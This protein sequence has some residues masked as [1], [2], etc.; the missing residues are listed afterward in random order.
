MNLRCNAVSR[1]KV[2]Q[3]SI[4]VPPVRKKRPKPNPDEKQT[5]TVK[6]NGKPRH[7]CEHD[8]CESNYSKRSRLVEHYKIKHTEWYL[9]NKDRFTIAPSKNRIKVQEMEEVVFDDD[10]K[11]YTCTT[12]GKQMASVHHIVRHVERT[13]RGVKAAECEICGQ[14]FTSNTSK[15]LHMMIHEGVKPHECEFCGKAFRRRDK[16]I[17]HQ[18]TVHAREWEMKSY[19]PDANGELMKGAL[20]SSE[21]CQVLKDICGRQGNQSDVF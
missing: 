13:H 16:M 18:K 9:E 2:Y 20:V 12:C 1:E 11:M 10:A 4:E 7:H 6:T 5:T 19:D 8:G 3:N 17:E 15:K 14:Q 21:D